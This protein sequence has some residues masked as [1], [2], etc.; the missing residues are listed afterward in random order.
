MTVAPDYVEPVPAWRTWLVAQENGR[1]TLR[2]VM[3]PVVWHPV[4]PALA[5][6]LRAPSLLDRL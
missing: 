4:Q 1:M 2:S 3:F 5:E 6:C